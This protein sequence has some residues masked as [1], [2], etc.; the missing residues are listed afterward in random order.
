MNPLR[1]ESIRPHQVIQRTG[2]SPPRAH[3]NNPGGPELG[4]A[5]LDLAASEE[6]E[7]PIDCRVTSISGDPIT[8][9]SPEH[10][11]SGL[12]VPA[13][14]WYRIEAGDGTERAVVEPVGVGEVFIVAGQS[15]AANHND[16][17]LR[18]DDPPGLITACDLREGRWQLGHDPQPQT[19][20]H[21]DMH[22]HGTPWP[23]A[24][25]LLQPLLRVPV[26][27]INVAV[28]GTASRQWLPGEEL[29][30]DLVAACIAAGGF[31][32]ILW[33]QGESDVIDRTATSEYVSRMKAIKAT[34]EQELGRPSAWILAKSTLHPTVY[35]DPKGEE[36]IRAAV[37][38]LGQCEG[39]LPG[40]DTDILGG[41][42]LNRSG[43]EGS[44]HFTRLGQER[45]GAMWFAS[46]WHHLNGEGTNR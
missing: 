9:V 35:D 17:Q 4:W 18:I 30:D 23:A 21:A 29:F 11:G 32:Y 19:R 27:M 12:R 39:F 46:L 3:V 1:L 14:G 44:R 34:L 37:D 40:P 7:E 28:G 10:A 31:R 16:T 36:R 26:G 33:Q 25:N 42:G 22:R 38:L 13:G 41:V 15:Y 24:M 5:D 20:P 6:R 45:A 2:F 8:T 43:M